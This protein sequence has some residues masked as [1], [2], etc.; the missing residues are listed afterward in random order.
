MPYQFE[1]APGERSGCRGRVGLLRFRW[2]RQLIVHW[3][4]SPKARIKAPP[5]MLTTAP[6]NWRDDVAAL[7]VLIDR[8]G[9]KD[10]ADEWGVHPWFGPVSGPE[11]G[12]CVGSI[13][14]TTCGNSVSNVHAVGG[15]AR[16]P[17]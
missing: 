10:P 11:W 8:V 9:A 2:Y 15:A 12:R 16:P 5:E 17:A 6:A 3:A 1:P 13:R 7:H 4:P 14:I